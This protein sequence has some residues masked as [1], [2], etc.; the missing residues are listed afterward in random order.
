MRL[1]VPGDETVSFE[2]IN[3][4]VYTRVGRTIYDARF[5]SAAMARLR[6]DPQAVLIAAGVPPA[7]VK[8][9]SFAIV[10]DRADMLNIVVPELRR[11]TD[12]HSPAE[13]NKYLLEIG[14]V[15]LRACKIAEA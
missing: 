12:F 10:E 8:N 11:E 14:F 5:D 3:T 6:T 1:F 15:T 4:D 2:N 13:F 7:S 9:F